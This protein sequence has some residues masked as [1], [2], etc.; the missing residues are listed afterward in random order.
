MKNI[1][2]ANKKLIKNMVKHFDETIKQMKK[3][4]LRYEKCMTEIQNKKKKYFGL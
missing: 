1:I 2:N 3:E 4:E